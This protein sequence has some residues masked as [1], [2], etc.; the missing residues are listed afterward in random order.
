MPVPVYPSD[1]PEEEEEV[2][3]G[4]LPTFPLWCPNGRFVVVP[5]H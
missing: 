1:E 4:E 2:P 5:G 3:D